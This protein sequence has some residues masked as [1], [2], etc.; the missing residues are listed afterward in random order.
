MKITD[1]LLALSGPLSAHLDRSEAT[2]SNWIVGHARLFSRLRADLGCN[3]DTAE[4]ALRWFSTNWPADLA[5]P[6]DIPRP[7]KSKEAA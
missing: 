1:Q 2:I 5:W 7:P 3:T 6:R 4:K